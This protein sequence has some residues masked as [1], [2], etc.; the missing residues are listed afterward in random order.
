MKGPT[1]NHR[2]ADLNRTLEGIYDDYR[3]ILLNA[4]Y[5]GVRLKGATRW[6]RCLE[7]L[8][9][10]GASGSGIAGLTLWKSDYGQYAWAAISSLAILVS[11]IKPIWN[12]GRSIEEHSQLWADYATLSARYRNAIRQIEGARD[13]IAVSG[14]LPQKLVEEIEAIRAKMVELAPRG[15]QHPSRRLVDDLQAQVNAEVPPATLWVA[16]TEED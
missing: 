13:Q 7:I 11:I 1:Q 14:T 12:L 16:P 6:N 4:K 10:V 2:I 8:I 3:T 9:A 15:D 5:N